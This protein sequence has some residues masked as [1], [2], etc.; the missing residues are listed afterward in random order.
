MTHYKRTISK[1]LYDYVLGWAKKVKA[2]KT[3]GGKCEC[4]GESNIFKLCFHHK[5]QEEKEYEIGYLISRR[6]SILKKELEKCQLL[7]FNC[8][9]EIHDDKANKE[10]IDYKIT[11]FTA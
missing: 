2:I 4:C 9:I 7:C 11:M 10:N 3:L 8:H 1:E 6:W 5:N